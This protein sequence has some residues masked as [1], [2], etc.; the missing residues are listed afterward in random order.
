M[1][2]DCLLENRESLSA[3][4]AIGYEERERLIHFR[5]WLRPEGKRG[6]D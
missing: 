4:L 5:K 3:H 6:R 2:S 1:G